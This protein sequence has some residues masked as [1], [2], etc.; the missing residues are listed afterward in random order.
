[1]IGNALRSL[2]ALM[3]DNVVNDLFSYFHRVIA[4]IFSSRHLVV[5]SFARPPVSWRRVHLQTSILLVV[6]RLK[7][8]LMPTMSVAKTTN[9]VDLS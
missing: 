3:T 5:V 9:N 4:N 8:R 1:M 6:L 7:F 2:C